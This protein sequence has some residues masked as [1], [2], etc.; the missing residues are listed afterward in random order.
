VTP[1]V[2]V[3]RDDGQSAL[4]VLFVGAALFGGVLTAMVTFGGHLTDRTR[5]QSAA[6]AAALGGVTGG[7]AV[8]T[9]L[10]ERHGAT[11]VSF[12][13]D[14]DRVT[15]IVRIDDSTATASATDAP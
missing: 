9:G 6:D 11:L 7:V 1:D 15:V 12:V 2:S 5:A 8:A 4:T 10:A 14:G 3:R 13:D